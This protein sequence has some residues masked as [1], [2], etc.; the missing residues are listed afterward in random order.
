[1]SQVKLTLPPS[2][3][4]DQDALVALLKQKGT[5]KK[6]SVPLAADALTQL[7]HLLQSQDCLLVTKVTLLTALLALEKSPDEA[8]FLDHFQAQPLPATLSWLFRPPSQAIEHCIQTLIQGNDLA[9]DDM[10]QAM[11]WI[12][13]TDVPEYYKAAILEALRLKGESLSENQV[14]LSHFRTLSRFSSVNTS[15]LIEIANA[16]DGLNRHHCFWPFLAPILASMGHP[17]LLHG[18]HQCGPKFGV[19]P[20]QVFEQAGP[21]RPPSISDVCQRLEDPGI[22]WAYLSQQEF[23][24]DLH[25]LKSL[26]IQ[27]VKRPLLS[28]LEKLLLPIRHDHH[29]LL[30]SYTHPAYQGLLSQLFQQEFPHCNIL[31]VRGQEGSVQ[32]RLDRRVHYTHLQ[33]AHHRDDFV[34]T[35]QFEM[36]PYDKILPD[37]SLSARDHFEAGVSALTGTPSP[38]QDALIYQCRF[39]L[40][41]WGLGDDETVTAQ[42]HEVLNNGKAHAHFLAGL[43]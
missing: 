9:H 33:G 43:S 3:S 7:T 2:W 39:L 36:G 38:F 37:F 40:T 22:G 11:S 19:T 41:Q 10:S 26:R 24:P 27:M 32:L 30:T 34:D 16:Y 20:E 1:M 31:L 13:Q 21:F 4:S 15:H 6:M 5:G 23:S 12:T 14:C 25:A 8:A 18:T 35:S 17:V 29:Y 42:L 28:T